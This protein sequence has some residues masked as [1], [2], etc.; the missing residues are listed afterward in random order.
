MRCYRTL[1]L[2]LFSSSLLHSIDLDKLYFDGDAEPEIVDGQ[3]RSCTAS[4]YFE[5]NEYEMWDSLEWFE[6]GT[7]E[8]PEELVHKHNGYV[9]TGTYNIEI[10]DNLIYLNFKSNNEYTYKSKL[11]VLFHPR[12][13]FLYDNDELFFYSNNGFAKNP[14]HGPFVNSISTSSFLKEGLVNYKGSNNIKPFLEK[15]KPWVEGVEGN[16]EGEWLELQINS[17]DIPVSSF[18]IS[19]GYVSFDKPH[20][21]GY[22]SRVKK[23]RVT[24]EELGIDFIADL[25]DTPNFQEVKLP[26]EITDL[27]TTFRFTILEVYEGSK[28]EDT[29]VNLIVPLGNIE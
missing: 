4:I 16:G 22:N 10:I 29:C 25:E 23:L 7:Y 2:V 11:G 6:P 26:E 9:E 21:Y 13:L 15:L 20:L 14:I 1:L 18:L 17:Y 8:I 12:R 3:A 28:W 5:N 27:N 19:N 24:C